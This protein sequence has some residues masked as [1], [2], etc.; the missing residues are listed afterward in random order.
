MYPRGA[1]T[2]RCAASAS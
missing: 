2:V 1:A